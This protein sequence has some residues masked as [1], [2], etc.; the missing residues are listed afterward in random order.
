MNHIAR[1]LATALAAG[2]ATALLAAAP[3]QAGVRTGQDAVIS[4]A[5][6][7]QCQNGYACL[8]SDAGW[9]GTFWQGTNN[10]SSLPSGIDRKASSTFNNGN[11]CVAHF[12]TAQSY[13]GDVLAEPLGSIRQNLAL[14]ARGSGNWND[15]IRSLYWC[16]KG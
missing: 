12:T 7:T 2:A 15:V 3:A 14:D 4:P 6:T 16:S 13:G 1:V 5:S 8:W 10:N 9:V 11:N